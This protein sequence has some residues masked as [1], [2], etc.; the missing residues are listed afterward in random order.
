M[1]H[2]FDNEVEIA[3]AKLNI[4]PALESY[5]AV[6]F[7]FFN[8]FVL[9]VL[10]LLLVLASRANDRWLATDETLKQRKETRLSNARRSIVKWRGRAKG[11]TRP[12]VLPGWLTAGSR[13]TSSDEMDSTEQ[14]RS[15]KSRVV[16]ADSPRA[17]AT[18]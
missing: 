13:L 2:W 16:P 12:S 15:K 11:E 14:E 10:E 7:F 5:L 17:P 18:S 4:S 8:I 6:I 1:A 3:T 9:L